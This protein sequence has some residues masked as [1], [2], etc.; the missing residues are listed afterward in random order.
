MKKAI[1]AFLLLPL[2]LSAGLLN[3][4]KQELIS[5]AEL[6]KRRAIESLTIANEMCL[7][8]PDLES[9][10]NMTGLISSAVSTISITNVKEK[11]L[12]IGLS[13]IGGLAGNMYEKYCVYRYHLANAAYHL[14]QY[15]WY[16][17][18]SFKIDVYEEDEGSQYYLKAIDYLT[19]S[20]M[21]VQCIDDE[22]IRN[23]ISDKI[24]KIRSMLFKNLNNSYGILKYDFLLDIYYCVND[25]DMLLMKVKDLDLKSTIESYSASMLHNLYNARECWWWRNQDDDYEW[26]KSKNTFLLRLKHVAEA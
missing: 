1:F 13:L 9:R 11:F 12:A 16:S 26:V 20:D 22:F 14:E 6:H 15:R 25:I 17:E 5:Q 3:M 19:L 2:C 18:T 8:I 4:T 7:Y 10:A 23:H 24:I 21:I